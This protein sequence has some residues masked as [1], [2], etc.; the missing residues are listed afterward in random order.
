MR[1]RLPLGRRM[2]DPNVERVLREARVH[3]VHAPWRHDPEQGTMKFDV[4]HPPL[5]PG[6]E[7]NG[8]HQPTPDKAGATSINPREPTPFV[9]RSFDE[10]GCVG[11]TLVPSE[12]LS[13]QR[14][15]ATAPHLAGTR[16]ARGCPSSDQTTRM[17]GRSSLPAGSGLVGASI[18]RISSKGIRRRAPLAMSLSCTDFFR[19]RTSSGTVR[20]RRITYG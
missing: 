20:R 11:R 19:R 3:A 13:L 16:K 1:S 15:R 12:V 14:V 9:H 18:S 2:T 8:R 4:L 17:G 6:G 7:A 10:K 5:L